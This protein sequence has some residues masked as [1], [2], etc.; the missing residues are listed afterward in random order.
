M[1]SHILVHVA[2]TKFCDNPFIFKNEIEREGLARDSPAGLGAG[3]PEFESR[4]PD[5]SFQ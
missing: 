4:R 2:T 5:Q 3:G 1:R